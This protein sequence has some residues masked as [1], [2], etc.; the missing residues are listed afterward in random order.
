MLLDENCM[1]EFLEKNKEFESIYRI[2][3]SIFKLKNYEWNEEKNIIV[4]K[5]FEFFASRN[6]YTFG[7]PVQLDYN[8]NKGNEIDNNNINENNKTNKENNINNNENINKKC[9]YRY[10]PND[11]IDVS[12]TIIPYDQLKIIN[13][14]KGKKNINF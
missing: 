8:N 1:K 7:N 2:S 10:A 9:K 5:K 13:Q 6:S 14:L 4:I 12:E 11:K 3:G